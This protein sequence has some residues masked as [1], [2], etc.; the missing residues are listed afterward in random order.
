[1]WPSD[2]LEHLRTYGDAEHLPPSDLR[3]CSEVEIESAERE[4]KIGL[5]DDYVN[6]LCEVG[7]GDVYGGLGRWLHLDVSRPGNVIAHSRSI[8][9]AQVEEMKGKGIPQRRYPKDFLVIYDPLDGVL[10]GLAP[11]STSAYKGGVFCWDTEAHALTR[12]ADSF[13]EFLDF[14]AAEDAAEMEGAQAA[15]VA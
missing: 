8:Q 13:L 12:V 9:M 10:Y 15:V 4:T 14:L 1:M 11:H 7:T 2:Y 3:P 5:P 6:F